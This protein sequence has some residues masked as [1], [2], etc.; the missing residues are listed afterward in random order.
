MVG[1]VGEAGG[2]ADTV[3]VDSVVGDVG[4]VGEGGQAQ[5]TNG[6]CSTVSMGFARLID[7][8]RRDVFASASSN[9]RKDSP[10]RRFLRRA[11]T[12]FFEGRHHWRIRRW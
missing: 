6:N 3:V 12:E 9:G 1:T 7:M 5:S 11:I 2:L 10:S 4:L 8:N